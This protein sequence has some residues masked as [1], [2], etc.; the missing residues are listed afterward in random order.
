MGGRLRGSHRAKGGPVEVEF[1]LSPSYL[2]RGLVLGGVLGARPSGS[3]LAQLAKSFE[4]A[5]LDRDVLTQVAKRA[6]QE[7]QIS[8]DGVFPEDLVHAILNAQ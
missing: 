8:V 5:P 4:G 1:S 3:D 6:F 7:L 2:I